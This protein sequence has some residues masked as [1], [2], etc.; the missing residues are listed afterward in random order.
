MF[1]EISQLKKRARGEP[2][3]RGND[4]GGQS[5]QQPMEDPNALSSGGSEDE[6]SYGSQ[7]RRSDFGDHGRRG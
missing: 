4:N 7:D 3:S 2:R 5:S 1:S 6:D